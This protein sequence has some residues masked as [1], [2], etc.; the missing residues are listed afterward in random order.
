MSANKHNISLEIL[1][2]LRQCIQ[3][4][5]ATFLLK[6]K[7]HRGEPLNQKADTLAEEGRSGEDDSKL[8]DDR[9][10]RMVF[11]TETGPHSKLSN[12]QRKLLLILG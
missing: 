3:K 11:H 4:G 5:T 10:K 12:E 1:E 9:T 2:H 7:S 8:W 6:V